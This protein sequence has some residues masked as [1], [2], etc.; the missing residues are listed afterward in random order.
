M[1]VLP[2]IFCVGKWVYM[3]GKK[4][5]KHSC[6]YYRAIWRKK[7]NN[8]FVLRLCTR[9]KL[10][11]THTYEPSFPPSLKHTQYTYIVCSWFNRNAPPRTVY[12]IYI[13]I[14]IHKD[15]VDSTITYANIQEYMD[16]RCAYMYV[17]VNIQS[18]WST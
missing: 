6:V 9:L 5:S 14:Y 18:I 2:I 8:T 7:G 4:P 16:L 13:Y 12:T 17:W 10:L 11:I 15:Y 3:Y 1:K